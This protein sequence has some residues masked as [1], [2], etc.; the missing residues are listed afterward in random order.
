MSLSV[1]VFMFGLLLLGLQIGKDVLHRHFIS[2]NFSDR[3][4]MRLLW[5]LSCIEKA[6][7]L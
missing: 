4:G 6:Q 5:Q 7:W 1:C 2:L 3:V